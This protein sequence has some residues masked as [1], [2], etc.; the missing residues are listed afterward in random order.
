MDS[1]VDKCRRLCASIRDEV[2]AKVLEVGTASKS[3]RAEGSEQ[4]TKSTVSDDVC[5][6]V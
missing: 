5:D 1:Q 4:A 3:F 2:S 6:G